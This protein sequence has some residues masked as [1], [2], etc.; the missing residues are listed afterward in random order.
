MKTPAYDQEI[1]KQRGR[2]AS[3]PARWAGSPEQRTTSKKEKEAMAAKGEQCTTTSKISR[4][5]SVEIGNR[6][7]E[8]APRSL[9]KSRIAAAAPAPVDVISKSSQRN[10]V[11]RLCSP[12]VMP[13]QPKPKQVSLDAI[14]QDESDALVERLSPFSMAKKEQWA[15]QEKEKKGGR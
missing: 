2:L 9:V 4:Q 12:K 10:C 13:A 7:A 5:Q 6:M 14:T 11:D 3:H 15:Q 1:S 8:P